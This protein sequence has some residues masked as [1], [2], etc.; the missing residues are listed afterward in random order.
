MSIILSSPPHTSRDLSQ[1]SVT[2]LRSPAALM[3]LPLCQSSGLSIFIQCCTVKS[4]IHNQLPHTL[5]ERRAHIARLHKVCRSLELPHCRLANQSSTALPTWSSRSAGFLKLLC[6]STS[7]CARQKPLPR[8]LPGCPSG[9]TPF[10]ALRGSLPRKPSKEVEFSEELEEASQIVLLGSCRFGGIGS[11][12][13][14]KSVQVPGRGFHISRAVL[15]R[16]MAAVV[17]KRFSLRREG[18]QG[19]AGGGSGAVGNKVSR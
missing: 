15:R 14:V 4:V 9:W 3:P 1:C 16:A 5:C 19:V 6:Y 2:T 11:G 12:Y 17:L 8:T 10:H 7:L 13:G 18:S